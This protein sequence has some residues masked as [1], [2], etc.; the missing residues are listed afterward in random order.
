MRDR[1]HADFETSV[2]CKLGR[3]GI[4]LVRFEKGYR[5]RIFDP[6]FFPQRGRLKCLSMSRNQGICQFPEDH[7]KNFLRGELLLSLAV[8]HC[9]Q[10][11]GCH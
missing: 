6:R 8:D 2:S 5:Q 1:R 7:K 10:L 3:K 9:R 4:K 11:A